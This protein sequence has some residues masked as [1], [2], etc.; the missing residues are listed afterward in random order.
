MERVYQA[1]FVG[2]REIELMGPEV[3]L[4]LRAARRPR[5]RR[6]RRRKNLVQAQGRRSSSRWPTLSLGARRAHVTQYRL[7]CGYARIE[8]CPRNNM[9]VNLFELGRVLMMSSDNGV[10]NLMVRVS[11]LV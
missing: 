2:V 7:N 9:L 11:V 6:R 8:F 4:Y 3:I 5:R 10:E 1:K